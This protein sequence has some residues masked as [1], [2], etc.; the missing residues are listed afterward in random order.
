[1]VAPIPVTTT[2]LDSMDFVIIRVTIPT[3]GDADLA[4]TRILNLATYTTDKVPSRLKICG[5]QAR[6]AGFTAVLLQDATTD[7]HLLSLTDG[8]DECYEDCPIGMTG[9]AGTTGDLLL[10]TVG[11]GT[12]DHGHIILRCKKI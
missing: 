5:V 10:T 1:M 6:L 9:A 11:I 3:G 7:V 8:M 12:T 4:A 2:L